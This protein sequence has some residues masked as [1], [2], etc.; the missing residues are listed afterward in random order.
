MYSK[1]NK[2]KWQEDTSNVTYS[3]RYQRMISSLRIVYAHFLLLYAT[4]IP[5]RLLL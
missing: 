2:D 3:M 5:H 1:P 4:C